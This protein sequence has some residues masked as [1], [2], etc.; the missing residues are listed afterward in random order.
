M[1][2]IEKKEDVQA[3]FDSIAKDYDKWKQKNAYYYNNL[4]GFIKRIVVPG[5][6]VLEIGCATGNILA[7]TQ[8]SRG[9]GIDISEE[10]IKLAREKYPHLEFLSTPIENF[11][12]DEKFDY[13]IMVDVADHVYDIMDVFTAVAHHCH[14]TTRIILTTISPWWQ[15]IFT[16]MEKIGAKMP[17]GPHNF[18]EISNITNMLELL[19]FK[20][21]FSGYMLLFPKYIPIFSYLANTIGVRLWGLRRLSPVQYMVIQPSGKNEVNLRLGCS[22]VIPCYNEEGNIE[23]AIRKIPKMGKYTEIIVV[24][25]GSKDRTAE[26]VRALQKEYQNLKL[27]DYSPNRGKGHAV[28]KGFESATQEVLMILDADIS[29]PP[30]ELPRFFNPLNKAQAQFVNGTRLVYPMED[31]A[32]RTLNLLGNKIFG[33]IMSFITKQNLSDTL[34]GTKAFYKNDFKFMKMGLDKWGDFDFLFGAAKLGSRILEIPVHYKSRR[35]GESKMKTFRHGIHLLCA[36]VRGF[37]ELVVDTPDETL[38]LSS[39]FPKFWKFDTDAPSERETK[40]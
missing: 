4:K 38:N 1:S 28:Q 19:D 21:N 20:V 23:E 35:S 24:N 13:I 10:M 37:R 32:M 18:V 39:R 34:C 25:D 29:V 7:S 16:L 12:G 40:K 33:Q 9:V 30:E 22:V 3:H 17:E 14:P 31:Q 15:P 11:K 27:I 8:P 26:K 2:P 5:G 6:R 36:C